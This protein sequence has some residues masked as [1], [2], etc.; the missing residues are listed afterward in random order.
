MT[1]E[2][3]TKNRKTNFKGPNKNR[4]ILTKDFVI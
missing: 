3:E 4:T 2:E 1:N